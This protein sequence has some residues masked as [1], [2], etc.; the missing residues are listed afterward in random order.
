MKQGSLS[1]ALAA[2]ICEA[3]KR[4]RDAEAA[5]A[6]TNEVAPKLAEHWEHRCDNLINNLH[7]YDEAEA[8]I[9][10]ALAIFPDSDVFVPRRARIARLRKKG[11]KP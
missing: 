3:Q 8:V 2:R 11:T 10:A 5:W 7:A 4:W 6:K 9:A 1:C